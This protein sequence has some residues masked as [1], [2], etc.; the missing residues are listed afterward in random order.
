MMLDKETC[1]QLSK[2]QEYRIYL[3]YLQGELMEELQHQVWEDQSEQE[4]HCL[5]GQKVMLER[6]IRLLPD[7]L[8]EDENKET[9]YG[10][11]SSR[12]DN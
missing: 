8:G 4:R 12:E 3:R 11:A 7:L 10:A 1:K 6:I 2:I 5:R 9:A